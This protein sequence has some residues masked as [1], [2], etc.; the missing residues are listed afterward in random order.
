MR[1]RSLVEL[2]PDPAASLCKC[3]CSS[4]ITRARAAGGAWPSSLMQSPP[5]FI[6]IRF[7]VLGPRRSLHEQLVRPSR[8]SAAPGCP[9]Y[10]AGDS[11]KR[12]QIDLHAPSRRPSRSAAARSPSFSGSKPRS[13]LHRDRNALQRAGSHPSLTAAASFSHTRT[14]R[15][16]SEENSRSKSSASMRRPVSARTGV[17]AN[18]VSARSIDCRVSASRATSSPRP[19]SFD[20]RNAS[21][22]QSRPLFCVQ[23]TPRN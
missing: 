1:E 23:Q 17:V 20:T 21:T 14:S 19:P 9:P 7:V 16:G 12:F 18:S 11:A 15:S 22:V 6:L 5:Q 4:S 8:G 13:A 3:R 2:R 10:N